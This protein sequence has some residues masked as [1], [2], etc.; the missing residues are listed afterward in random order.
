VGELCRIT[1]VSALPSS[2]FN[3]K[4]NLLIPRPTQNHKH[5]QANTQEGDGVQINPTSTNKNDSMEYTG[6]DSTGQDSNG[7]E[8][9]KAD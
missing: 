9:F 4:Q 1:G 5:L 8:G 6:S 7:G 3:F 2:K